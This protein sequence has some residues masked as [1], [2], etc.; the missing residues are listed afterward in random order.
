MLALIEVETRQTWIGNIMK[1]ICTICGRVSKSKE[2]QCECG[3]INDTDFIV[4]G[5]G[6]KPTQNQAIKK[7]NNQVDVSTV[8]PVKVALSRVNRGIGDLRRK[9]GKKFSF[10][11]KG[12][13][14]WWMS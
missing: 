11:R 7:D 12:S 2:F 9:R 3:N 10:L 14:S 8:E 13:I 1:I 4:L 6:K 5:L